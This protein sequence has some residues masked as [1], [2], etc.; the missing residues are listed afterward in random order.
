MTRDARVDFEDASRSRPSLIPDTMRQDRLLEERGFAVRHRRLLVVVLASVVVLMAL[1]IGLIHFNGTARSVERSRITVATVERGTFIRDIATDGQVV[2]A[3]SPTIYAPSQGSVVLSVHAGD[4][5]QRG[6]LLAVLDSP[7][8]AAKLS[9]EEAFLASLDIDWQRSRLQA[10]EKLSQLHDALA[11]AEVDEKTAQREFERSRKA[12]ELGSYSELQVLRAQDSLEKARFTADQAN[13]KFEAQ[14]REN[15]FDVEA[16]KSLYDRQQFLVSDLRRQLAALQIRSPVDG[17]VGQVQ[18]ADHATVS[19][20]TPL[21]T[22]VDLSKLEVEIKVPESSAH[23]IMPGMAADLE[24][25]GRDWKATVSG[26]SPE[27]VNGQVVARLRFDGEKPE[28]LRQSERL[29]VRIFID[30]RNNVLMV[31]RGTFVDQQGLGFAYVVRGNIAERRRIRIGATSVRKVEI[32]AGATQG[33][34]LVVSGLDG[35]GDAPRVVISN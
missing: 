22:V 33:E 20:D 25:D 13:A 6:E 34:Q 28:G 32:L 1:L 19:K 11:Q 24:R 29:S 18:I 8:L 4:A 30:R 15:R 21:L 35:I 12:Y 27:V 26:I 10:G 23:D 3:S 16:R 9:Q 14:P 17:R 2:A 31:D 5:V 7:E